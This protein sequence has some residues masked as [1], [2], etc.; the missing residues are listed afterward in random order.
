MRMGRGAAVTLV[1]P[2]LALDA[3]LQALLATVPEGEDDFDTPLAEAEPLVVV[4]ESVAEAEIASV[5]PN[6]AEESAAVEGEFHALFFRIGG[7]TLA[8]PVLGLKRIVDFDFATT[9]VTAL[10]N[11]PSWLLGLVENQG[12]TLGVMHTAE[13]LLGQEK[14]MR[15]DFETQPYRKIIISRHGRYGFACDEVLELVKL[16]PEDIRWR[17]T[18]RRGHRSWLMGT[19]SERLSV[20][21]DLAE[22]TPIRR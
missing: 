17:A 4:V 21:V 15:R 22:L 9:A 12:E 16:R 11:Q 7:L 5:E 20:L 6:P 13:L 10:P 8:T 3:Y 2:E 14:S 18:P 1:Q 19:V